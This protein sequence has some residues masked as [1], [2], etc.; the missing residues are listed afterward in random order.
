MATI[1]GDA[2]N[3]YPEFFKDDTWNEKM[4]NNILNGK[5]DLKNRKIVIKFTYRVILD[6]N[7][8]NDVIK[9]WIKNS[10]SLEAV[11]KINGITL[12]KIRNMQNYAARTLG[13]DLSYKGINFIHLMLY[14]D[15]ISKED[16]KEIDT[17]IKLV[18]MKRGKEIGTR[19]PLLQNKDLLVNIPARE[20]ACTLD[21]E[22]KW[23]HFMQLLRPYFISERKKAQKMI[24]TEYSEQAAYLN[25]LI[26]PGIKMTD[27]DKRRY[28]EIKSLLGEDNE[29]IQ[30][31]D[32]T[33]SDKNLVDV[34]SEE[35]KKEIKEVITSKKSTIESIVEMVKNMDDEDA[36]AWLQDIKDRNKS[37]QASEEEI[38]AY[39]KLYQIYL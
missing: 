23:N 29:I 2:K 14:R 34:I 5:S 24:N 36:R 33:K 19:K 31:V 3:F 27:D 15:D 35:Q 28:Q 6:N 21:N 26:T 25:Y 22:A 30:I 18:K 4:A 12:I 16:W 9:Q 20:F 38:S 39:T 13:E 1:L 17:Q 8:L 11:A 32:N 37:G 7:R 10:L